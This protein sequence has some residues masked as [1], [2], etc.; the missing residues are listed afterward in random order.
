MENTTE[1]ADEV[2]QLTMTS[3]NAVVAPLKVVA[4]NQR[5]CRCSCRHLSSS[6]RLYR[7]AVQAAEKVPDGALTGEG[8]KALLVWSHQ[9]KLNG[10]FV[11]VRCGTCYPPSPDRLGC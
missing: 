1:S 6:R 11:R 3:A 8:V 10:H 9:E 4:I 7:Q 2:C 5:L